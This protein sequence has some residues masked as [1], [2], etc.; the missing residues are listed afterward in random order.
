MDNNK[1]YKKLARSISNSNLKGKVYAFKPKVD[2]IDIKRGYID[3]RF[4][5]Q[6]NDNQSPVTEISSNTYGNL[7]SNPFYKVVKLRWRIV[8]SQQEIK[9]SNR[10]SISEHL[11]KMPQLKNRLVNLLEYSKI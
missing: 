11:R 9:D 3:R 1:I 4:V 7:Q 5:Q 2:K 10:A 6:C 8:G